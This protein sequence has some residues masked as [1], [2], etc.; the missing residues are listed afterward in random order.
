MNPHPSTADSDAA[1]AWSDIELVSTGRF[2]PRLP[3]TIHRLKNGLRVI[4]VEDHAAPVI[5]YH[6]WY[7][8]GSR[9]EREGKTGIAHLFEHLMFNETEHLPKGEFDRR[10]EEVGAESNAST[11]LDFT[12]YSI[13]APSER[14]P[15]LVE[16]E[17]DRM[18]N[19]VLRDPQVD[20]E[21]EVVANER[22]YRVDDDVEGAIN[23]LLWSTAFLK[24]PYKWPT[25]GWMQDILGFTTEDCHD[26]YRSYYAPNNAVVVVTGDF[27]T[28][29]ALDSI[30]RAYGGI[31]PSTLPER[32]IPREPPQTDERRVVISKPTVSEKLCMGYKACAL[33]DPDHVTLGLLSEIMTGGRA[34]RLYRRLVRELELASEVRLFIG[35]FRDPGLAELYASARDGHTAEELLT[36]VDQ[37][38]DRLREEP[39]TP[40]E[41]ARARARL[42]LGFLHGLESA[43]GKAHTL[44]F[45]DCV[46]G[47][48]SL[49]FER[50][51]ALARITPEDV[52]RVA[53]RTFDPAARSVVLV[54]VAEGAAASESDDETAPASGSEE[55][56]T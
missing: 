40:A 42:E 3:M 52:L 37:E 35:P 12:Q 10:L 56:N 28:A 22:R 48:P 29:Q 8:V 55:P 25:I 17:A 1:A 38:L 27:D 2:G 26:F 51:A 31:A 15:M 24:H 33:G 44:G 5:A 46:L 18:Q 32:A 53:R 14:L 36:V 39:V 6:T 13:S 34:S 47:E 20:S 41:I 11:W 9:D 50:L 16:I 19:L 49:A 23:E 45:Y 43:D 21:K 30:R 54:R 4:L 7:R